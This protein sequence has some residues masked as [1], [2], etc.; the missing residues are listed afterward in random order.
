M[1]SGSSAERG[2]DVAELQVGVDEHDRVRRDFGEARR[3]VDRER[4]L[5]LAALRRDDG[6][7]LGW[8][9]RPR[10]AGTPIPARVGAWVSWSNSSSRLDA[11]RRPR[12]VVGSRSSRRAGRRSRARR[13]IEVVGVCPP[14]RDEPV[15]QPIEQLERRLIGRVRAQHGV[16]REFVD[17]V[18]EIGAL[19]AHDDQAE[20]RD[21]A[22]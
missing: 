10:A 1:R 9:A 11:A 14:V 4:R 20:V 15:R 5:A 22:R 2:G 19:L 17:P 16:Q 8:R 12:V 6:D 7:R 3:E 21:A 13:G 18:F